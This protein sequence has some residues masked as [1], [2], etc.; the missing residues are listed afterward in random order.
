[1]LR[2]PNSDEQRVPITFV[3]SILTYQPDIHLELSKAQR[4]L[5]F[6]LTNVIHV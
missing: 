5:L 1:M 4:K 2:Q 6:P 3:R